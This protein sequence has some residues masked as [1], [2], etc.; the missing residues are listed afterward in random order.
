MLE[1]K[2][3]GTSVDYWSFGILIFELLTGQTPYDSNDPYEIL[4]MV[5]SKRI[6]LPYWL[7]RS[8][9]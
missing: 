9:K 3:Y 7:T 4:E 8:S 5:R 2:G 6:V 1:G